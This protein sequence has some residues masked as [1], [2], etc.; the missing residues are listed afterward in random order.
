MKSTRYEKEYK[1]KL[2]CQWFAEM[3]NKLDSLY[4]SK[5]IDHNEYITISQRINETIRE[6]KLSYQDIKYY[7][8]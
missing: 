8:N 3:L 7:Q 2:R 6:E 4:L 1:D 5:F